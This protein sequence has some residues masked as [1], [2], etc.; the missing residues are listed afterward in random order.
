M[1]SGQIGLIPGSMVLPSPPNFKGE[2]H[3]A[4]RHANRVL[5]AMDRKISL[6][7]SIQV[8]SSYMREKFEKK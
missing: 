7:N 6:L 4:L 5:C 1:V 3:L 2:C 8:M